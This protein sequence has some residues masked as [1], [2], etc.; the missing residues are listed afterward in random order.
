MNERTL[1]ALDMD[2]S[3]FNEWLLDL[4]S[5]ER[6]CADGY[7]TRMWLGVRPSYHSILIRPN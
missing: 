4:Y 3:Y 2:D 1:V 7:N 6:T 5:L